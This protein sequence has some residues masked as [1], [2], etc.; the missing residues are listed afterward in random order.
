[1]IR[2][3]LGIAAQPTNKNRKIITPIF[4]LPLSNSHQKI[5]PTYQTESHPFD[6]TDQRGLRL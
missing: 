3:R 1:M 5:S 4:K 6:H 2:S